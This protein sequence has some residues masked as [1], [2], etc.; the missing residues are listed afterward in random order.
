MMGMDIIPTIFLDKM[1]RMEVR[2]IAK[3]FEY[4]KDD[5]PN[6]ESFLAELLQWQVSLKM[7]IL[8]YIYIVF[9]I[10]IFV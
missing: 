6:N 3:M 4:F 9:H 2:G 1:R 10:V 5:F 8:E 7:F